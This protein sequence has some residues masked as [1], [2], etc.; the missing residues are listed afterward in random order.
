MQD[1]GE[2]PGPL[3]RF[4]AAIPQNLRLPFVLVVPALA[5]VAVIPFLFKDEGGVKGVFQRGA[6]AAKPR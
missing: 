5:A 2:A 1:Q 4:W 6:A 3:S